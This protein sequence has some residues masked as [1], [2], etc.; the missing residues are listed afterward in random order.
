MTLKTN[1]NGVLA[2]LIL[3]HDLEVGQLAPVNN[4]DDTTMSESSISRKRLYY[5]NHD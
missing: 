1:K 4:T 3:C 5:E 2:L